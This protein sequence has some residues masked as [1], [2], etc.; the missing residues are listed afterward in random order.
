MKG[1]V[2]METT[3]KCPICEC[4]E[5]ALSVSTT[6]LDENCFSTGIYS[7]LQFQN[8]RRYQFVQSKKYSHLHTDSISHVDFENLV[9]VMS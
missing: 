6:N 2:F 4:L 3:I 1:E 9:G 5:D 7:T 8:R